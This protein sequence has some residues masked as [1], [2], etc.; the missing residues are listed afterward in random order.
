VYIV[1]P[2][3]GAVVAAFTYDYV[4]QLRRS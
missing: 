4:A 2:I 3:L 1:G